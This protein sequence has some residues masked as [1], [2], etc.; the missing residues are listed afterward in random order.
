MSLE[1]WILPWFAQGAAMAVDEF[2]FHRRRGLGRWERIGHPIDTAA[3]LVPYLIA[4][5]V[6][7]GETAS[8]AFVVTAAASCLLITKDEWVHQR[9][10]GASEHWLHSV[11]FVLH[12]LGMIAAWV[13]WTGGP[14][15]RAALGVQIMLMFG[16][17]AYQALYWGFR[18]QRR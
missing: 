9:E 15:F 11:L 13:A 12:P 6:P 14:P 16:F 18:G 3:T 1:L 2:Y 10:C 4:W 17:M 8:T 7:V 5:S